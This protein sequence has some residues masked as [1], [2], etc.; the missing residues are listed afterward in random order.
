MWIDWLLLIV[1]MMLLIK[2]ADFFVDGSSKIAKAIKIPPLIIGLTL[3]SMGT[4][5]PELSVSLQ[6]ALAGSNDLSFWNVVGSNIF[7]TF[8]I[9]GTASFFV[10]LVI[11]KEMKKYDIP[12][13]VLLYGVMLL[14]GFVITPYK[15]DLVESI[16]FIILF[17]AY[18]TL[19]IVRAKKGKQEVVEEQE[20]GISIKNIILSILLAVAGVLAILGQ[21][22]I[23]I[24]VTVVFIILMLIKINNKIGETSTILSIICSVVFA[25]AGLVA[26]IGGG[27]F[28]VDSASNIAKSLGMS[29][30]LVGLTIVAVGTSLP[31]LVTSVVA[32]IK[33][34]NDIAIGNV[35][36][37]N[38]F[39]ILFILG[40]SSSISNLSISQKVSLGISESFVDLLVLLLSGALVLVF[41][42]LGKNIKKWQGAIFVVLYVGYIAY[43]IA[44]EFV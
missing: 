35:I 10:P 30:A 5:A 40:I 28:V 38:I 32:S 29:E 9:L 27:T 31:E 4:S 12:I 44:R 22:Y 15:L 16:I 25:G 8:F 23:A 3:V 2:G 39:N 21:Y 7:N 14:F 33:K 41:S 1:G 34:E 17:I 36:G 11:S 42:R 43:I 6:A 19:L 18:I 13:M 24:G 20:Q 37:S 26:I